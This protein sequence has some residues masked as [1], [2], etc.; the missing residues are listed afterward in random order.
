MSV[1]VG[2]L[3][4]LIYGDFY[5]QMQNESKQKRP[6]WQEVVFRID[7]NCGRLSPQGGDLVQI[8]DGNNSVQNV[9]FGG[10][11]YNPDHPT[12][13]IVV[14]DEDDDDFNDDSPTLTVSG[15]NEWSDSF[16][17]QPLI[18]KR[19][20]HIETYKYYI[21][22]IGSTNAAGYHPLYMDSNGN[23]LPSPASPGINASGTQTVYN[24]RYVDVPV[25]KSWEWSDTDGSTVDSWSVTFYLQY[26]EE[27]VS[28][29]PDAPENIQSLWTYVYDGAAPKEIT[30]T[31]DAGETDTSSNSFTDLP[32]Y[33]VHANGSVYRLK[34]AVDEVEY[35]LYRSGESEPYKTWSKD[36]SS[37]F[38]EHYSPIYEVDA[39]QASENENL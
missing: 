31:N 8:K 29:T 25:N 32:M 6:P 35:K 39:G 13:H 34:Y 4:T 18:G 33:K 7:E 14:V 37:S 12:R 38:E 20:G 22:E 26:R 11:F 28:G 36:T 5:C 21:E 3:T 15:A 30:V 19:D 17:H 9:Q 1:L 10:T 27:Y 2:K 23:L 24:V 16:E